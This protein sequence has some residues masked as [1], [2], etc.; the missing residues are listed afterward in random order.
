MEHKEIR[1]VSLSDAQHTLTQQENGADDGIV[2]FSCPRNINRP[3][4]AR[5]IDFLAFFLCEQGTAVLQVD[6]R[7]VEIRT[8]HLVACLDHQ[9]LSAQHFSEDFQGR[10]VLFSQRLAQDGMYGMQKMWPYLAYLFQHPVIPLDA[11]GQD[12]FGRFYD[13]LDMRLEKRSYVFRREALSNCMRLFFY[14]LCNFI[15]HRV[16]QQPVVSSGGY[17]LFER[18]LALVRENYK[19]ER[20]VSWYGERLCITPKYLSGVVKQVSGRTAGEWI[21]MF[22][23]VEIKSLLRNTDYSIKEIAREL[24]FS[25][26]SFLGKYFRNATGLSPSDYRKG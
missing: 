14:D 18:F 20:N 7:S 24:N 6:T 23:L 16:E 1:N 9:V 3:E 13:N 15:H 12:W 19:R 17:V 4:I 11:G 8:G 26:Q 22:V 2:T 25:N 5:K 10:G 21:T